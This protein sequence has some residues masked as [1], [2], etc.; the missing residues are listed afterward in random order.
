MVFGLLFVGEFGLRILWVFG[1]YSWCSC[2]IGLG[3]GG[4]AW[5]FAWFE[6]SVLLG[7]VV[8]LVV[9][10]FDYLVYLLVDLCL[11]VLW[12]CLLLVAC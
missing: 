9:W 12:L 8:L 2:L 11:L 10:C 3:L 7:F 1:L 6:F 4:C 5:I